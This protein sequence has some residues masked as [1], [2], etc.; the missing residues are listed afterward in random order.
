M[1]MPP[2]PATLLT[3]T[4]KPTELGRG[5][6]GVDVVE[7]PRP[8]QQRHTGVGGRGA[9]LVLG[10]EP[11][12]LLG[13]RPDEHEAGVLDRGRGV[14]VL[15]EEPVA[16]VDRVGPVLGGHREELLDPAVAGAGGR[17]DGD[18]DRGELAVRRRAVDVGE[19]RDRL[20][21]EARRACG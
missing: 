13:R 4:G 7:R 21:A 19:H 12:D 6:R 16:G 20:D 17:A 9:R 2:P 11:P 18:R 14:G 15:G 3:R 10:A 8:A 1:P 5:D